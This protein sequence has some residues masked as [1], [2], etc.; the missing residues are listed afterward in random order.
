M[1]RNLSIVTV[2][3][4]H[5][6]QIAQD[7][8]GL[9]CRQ[10]EGMH[11]HHRI[12][13]SKGGTNDPSNL[14]VCSPWF[15][16]HVWH[17]GEAWI[18]WA[19]K[20]SRAAVKVNR[21]KRKNDPEWANRE[22]TRNS[23]NGRKMHEKGKGTPEYSETQRLKSLKATVSKR[24]H[25]TRE[26]YDLVWNLFV[27]GFDSGYKISRK[28]ETLSAKTCSNMLNALTKGLTFDQV[29]SETLYVEEFLRLRQ[30][31]VQEMLQCYDD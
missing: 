26:E 1:D 4:R 22:K 11:V 7:N 24:G 6:R 2:D 19:L 27:K 31:P 3:K 10:M 25:W 21:Y 28:V 8:W 23:I 18:E 13:R 15:H 16:R 12:P 5:Y 29:T 17:D 14:Y 30:S 9:T 20:G